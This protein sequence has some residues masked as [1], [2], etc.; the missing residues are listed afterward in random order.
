MA[1]PDIAL[2]IRV[3]ILALLGVGATVAIVAALH[4]KAVPVGAVFLASLSLALAAAMAF[5]PLR[6]VVLA[7]IVALAPVPGMLAAVAFGATLTTSGFLAVYAFGHLAA[8]IV[9]GEAKRHVLDGRE[10]GEAAGLTLRRVAIP[11]LVAAMAG[12][13]F[14]VAWLFRREAALGLGAAA[15]IASAAVSVL[16]IVPLV[17]S[18]LPFGEGFH[19]AANRAAERREEVLRLST[20]VVEPRWA[21]SLSGVALVM[22]VLGWFGMAHSALLAQPALWRASALGAFLIA[23]ALGRDWREALAAM[24][25]LATLVLLGLWL[26]GRATGR[27]TLT[28]LIEIAAVIAA[29]GLVMSV[30]LASRQRFRAGG[31][32]SAIARLRA[33]E[34]LSLSPLFGAAGAAVA[35][36]PWVVVHGSLATLAVLFLLAGV[37]ALLLQPAIATALEA[38]VPRRRSLGQLYGRG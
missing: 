16:A 33:L 25:A 10:R 8:S 26:W 31:D 35:L 34:G 12:G 28:T 38:V 24:L 29:S 32:E 23:F 15:E 14:L 27:P 3:A 36:L 17:A 11:M 5:V 19:T 20:R 9:A 7:A 30:A 22:A 6:H 2:R 13:A 21:L 1:P 4:D 18:V 37:A